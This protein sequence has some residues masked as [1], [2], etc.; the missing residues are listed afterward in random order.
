[1]TKDDRNPSSPR[2]IADLAV[3]AD[4]FE[5]Q[6]L[7]RPSAEAL[8][9]I[10]ALMQRI[11]RNANRREVMGTLLKATRPEMDLA[12]LDVISAVMAG[13]RWPDV[14]ITVASSPK[15]CRSIPRAP[16]GWWLSW[17]RWDYCAVSPPRPIP[18]ASSWSSRRRER[19]SLPSFTNANGT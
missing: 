13:R 5:K 4:F 17:S 18:V 6:G 7:S 3:Q 1:M 2:L 11:R 9:E 16:A 10:D 12:Q 19:L 14:E 15:R 8:V